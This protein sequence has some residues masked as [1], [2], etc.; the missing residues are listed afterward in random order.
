MAWVLYQSKIPWCSCV[1]TLPLTPLSF[2]EKY[3]GLCYFSDLRAYCSCWLVP[4]TPASLPSLLSWHKPGTLLSQGL[5]TDGSL[6]LKHYSSGVHIAHR[7]LPCMYLLKWHLIDLSVRLYSSPIEI[8][9]VSPHSPSP[10]IYSS[11]IPYHHQTYYIC[12]GLFSVFSL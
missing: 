1:R 9:T 5:C 6:G 2:R 4:S 8:P 11:C 7:L 12:T 3:F 10:L